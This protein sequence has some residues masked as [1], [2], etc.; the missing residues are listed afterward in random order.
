MG[1]KEVGKIPN[2]LGFSKFSSNT[3]ASLSEYV[4]CI[5]NLLLFSSSS[6][7]QL[8][9]LAA[10]NRGAKP[11][12]SI[13][14]PPEELNSTLVPYRTELSPSLSVSV[15]VLCSIVVDTLVASVEP[16]RASGEVTTSV[17]SPSIFLQIVIQDFSSSDLISLDCKI[18]SLPALARISIVLPG[19][20]ARGQIRPR[21]IGVV[22]MLV[23]IHSSRF[24]V[25]MQYLSE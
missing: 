13:E 21:E 12:Q 8:P 10:T 5:R 2:Y 7:N 23:T 14:G 4:T 15:C 9:P 17:D 1:K 25:L 18:A 3:F 20:I 6:T 11:P 16:A 22:W 19:A 24:A